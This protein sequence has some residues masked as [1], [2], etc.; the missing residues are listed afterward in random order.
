MLRYFC[1]LALFL[2]VKS[3]SA[4]FIK[5]CKDGD[6]A[7]ILASSQAVIPV[8]APGV[9][10]LGVQPLDPL[11]VPRITSNQGSLKLTFTDTVLTGL[12]GCKIESIKHDRIKGKQT[13]LLRCDMV[14]DGDYV[15][16]GQLLILPV[17]GK[18]RYKID[19]RDIVIKTVTDLTTE[20]GPDGKEHWKIVKWRDS[21][22]VKT[23]VKHD[24]IKGK[25]TLLLRCDMV[26]DGDYVLDGQLLILPVQGKGRYKIDIR[27][28]VIKTV[29]DLTT[30]PGPDGKEHWKIVK[31]RDSFQ[32][33]TG[34]KFHFDNLFNGNKVLADP[35]IEFANTNWNDVMQEIAPPIVHTIIASVFKEIE[36]LYKAVPADELYIP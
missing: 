14:L 30:E 22:Q 34:V 18:G 10:E 28:I 27:D 35:V 24:R 3:A 13:L 15:L 26:L 12:K 11:K 33:K 17:Q 16:D 19:I 36:A 23:G 31:W 5:P 7:C 1:F 25:Q 6:N 9:P 4:P 21:F 2:N 32:V 20:Q 29:T 8:L